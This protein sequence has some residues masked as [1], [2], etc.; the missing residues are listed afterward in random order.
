M[1]ARDRIAFALDVE[2]FSSARWWAHTLKGY[3]GY[4]KIGPELFISAGPDVVREIKSEGFK[5]FLD[6]KFHDIPN[7]VSGAVR[8]AV[9]LGVDIMTIHL[10]GGRDMIKAAVDSAKK[11]AMALSRPTP[12]IVGVTVLTSLDEDDLSDVG[13]NRP[14]KDEEISLVRLAISCGIDGVV[15]SPMD[16]GYIRPFI[17]GGFVVITPG[18]RPSWATKG[19]QARIATPRGAIKEGADLLVIGRPIRD[20]SDPARAIEK[21]IEEMT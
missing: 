10:L 21:I 4:F 5:C 13:I 1:V 14:L 19:D 15:C 2:D 20:A 11:E 12:K 7:T 3:V 6:L 16:I 9:R 8:S 17:P 18:I